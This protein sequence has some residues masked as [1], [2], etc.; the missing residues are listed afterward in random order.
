MLGVAPDRPRTDREVELLPGAT[1]LLYTDGLVERRND[2]D[3]TASAVL[4]DL[5]RRG[6]EL[7]LSDLCDHLVRGTGADTGDDMVV[8]ALRV[9][10]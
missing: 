2:P 1:L 6:K 4:L 9:S 10:A 7:P 3:D 5:V 8:L